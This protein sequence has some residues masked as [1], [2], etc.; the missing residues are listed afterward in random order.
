MK[1]IVLKTLRNDK[2]LFK[3]GPSLDNC[4]FSQC[5]F[6]SIEGFD[7]CFRHY[8][9]HSVNKK[10]NKYD[11]ECL[12]QSEQPEDTSNEI[13]MLSEQNFL[14]HDLMKKND[15]LNGIDEDKEEIDKSPQSVEEV[16]TNEDSKIIDYDHFLSCNF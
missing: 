10:V 8:K 5:N 3:D 11:T 12:K 15:F 9:N 13:N 2:G 16:D 7:F 4:I 1:S 14:Y 6:K